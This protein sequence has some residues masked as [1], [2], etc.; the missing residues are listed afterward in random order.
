LIKFIVHILYSKL[1][2]SY[3]RNKKLY[4]KNEH[5]G[6]F[7]GRRMLQDNQK[8]KVQFCRELGT[9]VYE[10]LSNSNELLSVF[11]EIFKLYKPKSC[12]EADKFYG[13][14]FELPDSVDLLCELRKLNIPD[15][16][17]F[18]DLA[19]PL[20]D[21]AFDVAT[22]IVSANVIFNDII[23]MYVEPHDDDMYIHL[24][25]TMLKPLSNSIRYMS[26]KLDKLHKEV[27]KLLPDLLVLD[28]DTVEEESVLPEDVESFQIVRSILFKAITEYTNK[29]KSQ[30]ISR[31]SVA[32]QDYLEAFA[33][34]IEQ[35]NEFDFSFVRE[36]GND[37]HHEIEYMD[38]HFESKMIQVSSGGS[39]YDKPV[40]C[41][42]QPKIRSTAH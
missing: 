33:N 5:V 12:E 22:R 34:G 6:E 14:R 30:R 11:E 9:I 25:L 15:D 21:M 13:L 41:I 29:H 2:E 32:I 36:N 18:Y 4:K 42:C 3:L 24:Y 31:F 40:G 1:W 16:D 27:S 8:S 19:A 10:I 23:T 26:E 28:D 39:I 35:D 38:F 37:E 7:G 20:R 17:E